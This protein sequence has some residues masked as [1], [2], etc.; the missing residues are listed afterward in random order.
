MNN[1]SFIKGMGL[2]LMV[3]A[4]AGAVGYN[5]MPRKKKACLGKALRT[6]GDVVDSFT[7][8]LGL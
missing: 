8:S 4:A 6:M 5:A 7:G 3:G 1:M 2:G